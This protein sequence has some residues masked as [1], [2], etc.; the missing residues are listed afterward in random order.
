MTEPAAPPG[1]AMDEIPMTRELAQSMVL[2]GLL[3][4]VSSAVLG[5]VLL[6]ARLLG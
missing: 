3:A 2:M 4:G 6:A 1:K 5:L